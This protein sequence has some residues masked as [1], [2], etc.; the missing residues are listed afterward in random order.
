MPMIRKLFVLTAVSLALLLCHGCVNLKPAPSLTENFMLGP[1]DMAGTEQTQPGREG[2]YILRPQLPTYQE[3]NRLGYRLATGE[4]QYLPHARWAEPLADGIARA[5]AQYFGAVGLGS[6]E[7]YYPWPNT[8]ATASR[9][10]LYFERFDATATGEV[11]VAVRWSL[12]RKDGTVDKGY[13]AA[14][15]LSW[16][17][18][19]ADT[20]IAAYNQA[21]QALAETIKKVIS[22]D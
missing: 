8:A 20:L 14:K 11:Q 4:L 12:T 15:D 7:G 16:Q 3:G 5:S 17:P 6:V 18:G 2:L 13:F 9:L 10:A 19:Q 22:D 21:L 1:I